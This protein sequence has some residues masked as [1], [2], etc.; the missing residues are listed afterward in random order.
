MKVL[1]TGANG[2]V[3]RNALAHFNASKYEIL[4]PSRR[5]LDLMHYDSVVD[6]LRLNKPDFIVHAAGKVGGIKANIEDPYA[7]LLENVTLG[8]NI[9]R[10]AKECGVKK[11][12]NLGSSCIY[13]R[14][15]I[16]SLKE[17][18]ILAGPLEPTN[19]GYALSKIIAIRACEYISQQ[20]DQ[21]SYKTIIPCNL[22]GPFDK[23]E[24]NSAHLIPAIITKVHSAVCNGHKTIEIWGD[25]SARREFM[26]S[27]DLGGLIWKACS[28]FDSMP[29]TMNA[30]IGRDYSVKEYYEI[31]ASVIGFEGSF[32]FDTSQ[33]VGIAQKLTSTKKA[34][35]WGWS[36]VT[37]LRTGIAKTYEF[38]KE[39]VC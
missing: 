5:E 37:D 35:A 22:Y 9:I 32:E 7:F 14:D 23:F 29:Q 19:E 33:P 36:P 21:F 17:S 30:G 15:G 18:D 31:A 25:G 1:L 38:Y 8:S 20:F 28:Q 26:F 12:L 39:L 3:G 4:A 2:M 24:G 11:L 6:F 27:A 13:P 34:Q 10:A 16:T